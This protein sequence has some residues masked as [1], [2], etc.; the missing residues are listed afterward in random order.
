M[1]TL[2]VVA[3][4][5]ACSNSSQPDTTAARQSEFRPVCR[6]TIG[7][8]TQLGAITGSPVRPTHTFSIVARDPVTGDLGVAVQSHWFNVGAL[9][10]WAEPGVGAVATQSFVEPAY[11][12]KGLALMRDGMSAPD[13]MAKLVTDDQ[14]SAVRQLGFVDAHG[15]AASH[16]GARCIAESRG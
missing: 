11:G 5:C 13:A 14:Q 3:T 16:T 8:S 2:I 10:T 15:R 4:V 6:E 9:V 1:R 12:P 7:G